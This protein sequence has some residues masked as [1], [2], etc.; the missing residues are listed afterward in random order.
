MIPRQ[1]R[2]KSRGTELMQGMDRMLLVRDG[3]PFG[4][5]ALD[6]HQLGRVERGEDRQ[7]VFRMRGGGEAELTGGEIEPGGVQAGLVEAQRAKVFVL[8]A[9]E[10]SGA[11]HPPRSDDA[12][13]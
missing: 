11:K 9:V 8:R 13:Y 7:Q 6:E 4:Q 10:L 5:V 2:A 3:L 12:T 1:F